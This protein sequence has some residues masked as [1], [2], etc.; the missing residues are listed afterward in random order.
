[1]PAHLHIS[2]VVEKVF[3]IKKKNY[4]SYRRNYR[5]VE[6]RIFLTSIHHSS[7]VSQCMCTSQKEII[8]DIIIVG[9]TN[10]QLSSLQDHIS[11]R[12]VNELSEMR[13]TINF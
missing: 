13:N 2:F 11:Q 7:E 6:T 5:K 1:M 3:V 4:G 8:N 12:V 10:Y 9:S